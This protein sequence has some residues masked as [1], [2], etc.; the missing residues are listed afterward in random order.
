MRTDT[1]GHGP[2]AWLVP[3]AGPAIEPLRVPA[4]GAGVTL[5]RSE[6]CDLP[7]P[8]DAEAVSRQHARFLFDAGAWRV[9]DLRSRWGT[10]VNGVKISPGA[11]VPVA[12]GDFVRINPWTFA[13]STHGPTR[14]GVSVRDDA[15]DASMHTMIRS[16]APGAAPAPLAE[17]LLALLLESAAAV[18]AAADEQALAGAV[19]DAA[20]R[21]TGMPNAALL[22]PIDAAGTVQVIASRRGASE[23]N[24]SAVYS[25]TLLAAVANG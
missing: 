4:R 16:M 2:S 3:L 18:H 8:P 12:D 11:Q 6:Q 13:F 25:R 19:L 9:I 1:T 10:Y 24:D 23:G 20:V 14:P 7:L 5:G 21:G 15:A 22:R 17:D